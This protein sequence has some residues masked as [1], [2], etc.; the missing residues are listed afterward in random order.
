M[1]G[2]YSDQ[3]HVAHVR[4]LYVNTCDCLQLESVAIVS[5]LPLVVVC[6]GYGLMV[7][8]AFTESGVLGDNT[9]PSCDFSQPSS[10]FSLYSIYGLSVDF[11][12]TALF[13]VLGFA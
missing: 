5:G 4:L 13:V 1:A 8:L 11:S 9:L 3:W 10:H 6:I 12:L 7:G 2:G